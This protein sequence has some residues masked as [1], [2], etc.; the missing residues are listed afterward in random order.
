MRASRPSKRGDDGVAQ[1]IFRDSY[2]SYP[3]AVERS[4]R[5]SR[6]LAGSAVGAALPT[7]GA[8]FTGIFPLAELLTHFRVQYAVVLVPMALLLIRSQPRTA[9]FVG[10]CAIYN[11]VELAPLYMSRT[12]AAPVHA[13]KIKLLSINVFTASTE[14]EAVLD[15]IARED[16]DVVIA[17]EVNLR[18]TDALSALH[19]K[20]PAR[21]EH[22]QSDN[23]GIA[24]YARTASTSVAYRYFETG[25][26]PTVIAT[27]HIGQETLRIFGV[28]PIPPVGSEGMKMRDDH[29]ARVAEEVR[30]TRD[31]AIVAGDLNVTPWSPAFDR[32]L[33]A[34]GLEDGRRGFGVI[35]TWPEDIAYARIPIDHVLVDPRI[36]VRSL[37]RSPDVG[38]DHFAIIAEL[39]L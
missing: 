36:T 4:V 27:C 38:S 5:W 34:A 10:V 2:S 22:P 6:V 29:L 13:R 31:L 14:H 3:R 30:K 16:P 7:L 11:L 32:F 17:L 8:F 1:S 35:A 20:Y 24:M 37:K 9:L 39:E 18:W 25:G 26:V 19:A 33:A 15:L 21:V 23:F 12:A 28:H